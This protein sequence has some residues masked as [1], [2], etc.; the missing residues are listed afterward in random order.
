MGLGPIAADA[1]SHQHCARQYSRLFEQHLLIRQST[2]IGQAV[3]HRFECG[4]LQ[5][6]PA[7]SARIVQF[8]H[9]PLTKEII[10]PFVDGVVEIV[11]PRVEGQLIE[12][13]GKK[14]GLEQER[15]IGVV[16]NTDRRFD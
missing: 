7:A 14:H 2:P 1:R 9:V 4:L 13:F 6:E 3:E 5:H 8:I 16:E 10:R 12:L 11:G 15:G